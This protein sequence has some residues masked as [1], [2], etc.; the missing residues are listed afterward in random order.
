[1][2][3]IIGLMAAGLFLAVSFYTAALNPNLGDEITSEEY[4]RLG[5]MVEEQ[6]ELHAIVLEKL[7]AGCKYGSNERPMC[8]QEAE[9]SSIEAKYEQYVNAALPVAELLQSIRA[10]QE[11]MTPRSLE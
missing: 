2:P 4:E 10:A 11:R 6:P 5:Q 8:I 1:M 9:F 3:L 7:E